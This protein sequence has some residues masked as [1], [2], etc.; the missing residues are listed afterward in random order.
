M[1]GVGSPNPDSTGFGNQTSIT[2]SDSSPTLF[3]TQTL[4]G[5]ETKPLQ[6][7]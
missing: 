3:L 5:L 1:V 7:K 2:A 6:L 4:E